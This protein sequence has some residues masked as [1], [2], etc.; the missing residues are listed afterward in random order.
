MGGKCYFIMI[1]NSYK[2]LFVLT[3][4]ARPREAGQSDHYKYNLCGLLHH[5]NL[6]I[7]ETLSSR[8][9]ILTRIQVSLSTCDIVYLTP[10]RFRL[11]IILRQDFT[12]LWYTSYG[13]IVRI[14]WNFQIY[15]FLQKNRFNVVQDPKHRT[16]SWWEKKN[17]VL[18]SLWK[19]I[20]AGDG[21]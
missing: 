9:C 15:F 21:R 14:S 2:N 13:D 18:P 4:R 19:G 1:S 8:D 7:W 3:E 12:R 10:C 20:L 6:T 17:F 11:E 16:P 5:K